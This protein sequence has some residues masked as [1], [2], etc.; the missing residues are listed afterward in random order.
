MIL[1]KLPGQEVHWIMGEP[2]SQVEYYLSYEAVPSEYALAYSLYL[3]ISKSLEKSLYMTL[4]LFCLL[5]FSLLGCFLSV[6]L[7]LSHL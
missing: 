2:G 1:Y 6:C 3:P 4:Y 5:G 7:W